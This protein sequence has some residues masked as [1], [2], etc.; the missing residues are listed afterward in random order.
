MTLKI[1]LFLVN[2]QEQSI[3][4]LWFE[5]HDKRGDTGF[6]FC[7]PYNILLGFSEDYNRIAINA[8]YELILIR[9][10]VDANVLRVPVALN[11]KL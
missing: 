6:Q 9:S 11:L 4:E 10:R 8:R 5:L 7:I 1:Y 2:G 3:V